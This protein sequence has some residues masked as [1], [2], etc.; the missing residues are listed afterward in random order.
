MKLQCEYSPKNKKQQ[1]QKRDTTPK[2]TLPEDVKQHCTEFTLALSSIEDLLQPLIENKEILNTK[3]MSP[4]DRAKLNLCCAYTVNTLFYM[5]LKTQGIDPNEHPVRDEL[6]RVQEYMN[7]LRDQ[8]AK[9]A[10]L[11]SAR[12]PP[13]PQQQQ[14]SKQQQPHDSQPLVTV[15]RETAQKFL[16]RA[17]NDNNK[18][19][20]Q[21]EEAVPQ[22]DKEN[23]NDKKKKK[24]KTKR[25]GA[26]KDNDNNGESPKK[27]RRKNK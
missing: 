26:S 2:D 27:R 9:Y 23:V 1:M 25:D 7:K 6:K 24:N 5:Y 13:P 18:K 15:D 21:E 11:S 10:S 3:E 19:Q 4:K 12:L 14:Q 17:L 16:T 8:S 22:E 20:R